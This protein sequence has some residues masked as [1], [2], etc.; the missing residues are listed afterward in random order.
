[1]DKQRADIIEQYREYHYHDIFRLAP[2]VKEQAENQNK[3]VFDFEMFFLCLDRH[4]ALN[5]RRNEHVV[6]AEQQ[7]RRQEEKQEQDAAESHK[8]SI[9]FQ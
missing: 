7:R 1:M 3:Q 4:S 5:R 6:T 2:P 8:E 9:L